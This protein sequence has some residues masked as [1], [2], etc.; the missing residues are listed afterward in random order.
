MSTC[1]C[2]FKV[3]SSSSSHIPSSVRHNY[4]HFKDRSSLSFQLKPMLGKLE[5][6]LK[7]VNQTMKMIPVKLLDAF[8]DIAFEIVD[9]PLLPSQNNFAPVE[10][11]GEAFRIT[12]IEGTIPYD[13]PEGVYIRNGPNPLFGGYKSAISIF[14]KSSHTWIE[15]EGMLHAVYFSKSNQSSWTIFY[16]NRYVESDTFKLEK[17]RRK[18]AFLPAAEGDPAAV[19]SAHLLNLLRFGMVDKYLSNTNVFEHSGRFYVTAEN[20]IP[21]EINIK[22][23]ETLGKWDVDGTWTRPF[24]SH[25]KKVRSTGELVTFG[26]YP[27]KPYF[28]IGI[29]S[30]DGKKVVQKV[31]L[32]FKRCTLSHEIGITQRYNVIM[33]FPL[34]IDIN[35]LLAG[36]P[37]IKYVK[38]EYARIG[39][40]PIYGDADSIK[41]FEVEPAAAFHIVNCFEDA[42]EVVVIACKARESIIPGPEFGLDKYEWF[43]S[44]FKHIKPVR[45][46]DQDSQDGAFFTRVYEWRL[47]MKSGEVKGK[48]LTGTEFSM[49]FPIINEKFTGVKNKYGYTQVIDSAASSISG[50]AKYGG[51]AKLHLEEKTSEFFQADQQPGEVTKIEYHKFPECTFCSGATFVPKFGSLEEDDGWITAFV[52]NEKTNISQVYIVDAK[53]ISSK[54]IAKIKLPSRVPYG[55]HGAFFSD[56]HSDEIRIFG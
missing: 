19:F 7:D 17:Q 14:G 13:F 50:M 2:T 25:A 34:V 52:H 38:K 35:R 28:E 5:H 8:V 6:I 26:F 36:G 31:D 40:M 29:I 20:H 48:Y 49:D 1:S 33:D 42:D 54:P 9:Q 24:S 18:L 51:L 21:Q 39:V 37:L 56:K 27:Q 47:N 55:F 12:D 43:S 3:C 22:T 23:L 30:A 16:N 10:E 15:G 44:G 45:K 53:N 11:L 46:S 41:W 4:D 32:K